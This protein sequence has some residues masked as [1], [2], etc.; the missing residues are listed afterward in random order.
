MLKIQNLNRFFN[1]V[2]CK[3][4]LKFS[5][6]ERKKEELFR[7]LDKIINAKGFDINLTGKIKN[8]SEFILNDKISF[9]IYINGGGDPAS[10]NGKIKESGEGKELILKVYSNFT[11]PLF[12]ILGILVPILFLIL[13]ETE[14]NEKTLLGSFIAILFAFISNLSGNFY[15][16]R[17]LKKTLEYLKLD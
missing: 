13:D 5:I 9:G 17:L 10:L 12:S 16:R 8:E 3:E 14:I 1:K 6:T 11:F 7:N 4:T 15:K 2:L